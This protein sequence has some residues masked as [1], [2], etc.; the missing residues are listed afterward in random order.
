MGHPRLRRRLRGQIGA[1]VSKGSSVRAGGCAEANPG[2]SEDLR[3]HGV[4]KFYTDVDALLMIQRSMRCMA[5]PPSHKELAMKALK[6]GSLRSLKTN[7]AQCARDEEI[8]EAFKKGSATLL[9]ILQMAKKGS[10]L[11]AKLLQA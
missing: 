1:R 5:T 11:C 6:R 2:T 8:C 7:G 4:A 9:C 3:R 10:R